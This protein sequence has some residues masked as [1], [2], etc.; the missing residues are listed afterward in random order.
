MKDYVAFCFLQG[1]SNPGLTL[2]LPDTNQSENCSAFESAPNE[3]ST[4]KEHVPQDGA[5]LSSE[6]AIEETVKLSIDTACQNTQ[7]S[8]SVQDRMFFRSHQTSSSDFSSSQDFPGNTRKEES[9]CSIQPFSAPPGIKSSSSEASSHINL[10]PV[11]KFQLTEV[12]AEMVNNISSM[13]DP[14]NNLKTECPTDDFSPPRSDN[15]LQHVHCALSGSATQP[16]I[17]DQNKN[18]SPHSVNETTKVIKSQSSTA[19]LVPPSCDCYTEDTDTNSHGDLAKEKSQNLN[20]QS[21]VPLQPSN[22]NTTESKKEETHILQCTTGQGEK[23]QKSLGRNLFGPYKKEVSVILKIKKNKKSS[24][25][26][27]A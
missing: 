3:I 7:I 16:E 1:I 9:N 27:L 21:S 15:E 20:Q 17:K 5:S 24:L 4:S 11:S 8:P 19:R 6:K 2:S 23:Q 25:M 22:S 18:K 12:H 14:L 10:R 13:S 26:S